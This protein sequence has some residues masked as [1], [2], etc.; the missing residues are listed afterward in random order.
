VIGFVGGPIPA[1]PANLPLLKGAAL[2]GVDIRQFGQHEPAVAAANIRLL[3]DWVASGKL[4][5]AVARYIP[6]SSFARRWQRLSRA[7]RWAR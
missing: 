2:V 4:R 5:P 1:L 7:R 6:L 3:W